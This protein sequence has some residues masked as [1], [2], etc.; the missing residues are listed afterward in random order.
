MTIEAW[1]SP[2]GSK[3]VKSTPGR[4]VSAGELVERKG[5]GGLLHR[6]ERQ[7]AF[8]LESPGFLGSAGF[9]ASGG[10]LLSREFSPAAGILIFV[11]Q[12]R[13]RTVLP[14]AALGTPSTRRHVRLGHMMRTVSSISVVPIARRRLKVW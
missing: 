6:C 1:S 12:F 3:A 11:P 7:A 5:T 8:F 9:L 14:R 10:F 13:Q 2:E 4:D